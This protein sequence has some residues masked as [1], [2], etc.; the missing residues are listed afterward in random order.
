MTDSDSPNFARTS[1]HEYNTFA[2]REASTCVS[3]RPDL[4]GV[5]SPK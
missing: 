5:P 2:A 1:P 4:E 3:T